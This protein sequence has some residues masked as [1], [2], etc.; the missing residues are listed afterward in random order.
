MNRF[1]Q[2]HGVEVKTKKKKKKDTKDM[3]P[4]ER[5][6]H[7]EKTKLKEIYDCLMFS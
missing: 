4:E 2:E 5:K 1:A 3:T 7:K 6:V